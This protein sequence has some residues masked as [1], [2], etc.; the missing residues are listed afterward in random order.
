MA[1]KCKQ[2]GRCCQN[3]SMPPVFKMQNQR[4]A[5]ALLDMMGFPLVDYITEPVDLSIGLVIRN[6]PCK[7]YNPI[8]HLC[9]DYLGRP[10]FCREYYCAECL[11]EAENGNEGR[12]SGE[13][14]EDCSTV[15]D[16][17]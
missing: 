12:S 6:T 3:F 5:K 13:V 16:A 2:C 9:M 17:D 10:D 8:S 11:K 4:A 14:E 15:K 7:N 1:I